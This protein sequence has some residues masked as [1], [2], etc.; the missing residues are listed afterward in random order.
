LQPLDS[1]SVKEWRHRRML[2]QQEV[3]DRAGTSL[4]TIQRIERGE[5]NVRPKTGR[6]VAEV[7]GVPIEELLP[8]VQAPL[9]SDEPHE[10]R[11]YFNFREAREQLEEYCE[12]WE[13][14]IS[15]NGLDDRAI[16]EFMSAGQGFIPV[17]DIALRAELH[18]LRRLTGLEGS[19]LIK[20]SEIAKA[21][22]RYL[23]VFSEIAKALRR[24]VEAAGVPASNVVDLEEA[25]E[26][27]ADM[28]RRAVG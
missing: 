26:R 22:D 3:A 28:P 23:D 4:F 6:A 10:E 2:S 7:L 21:N 14:R 9:W 15:K 24:L 5:G 12:Q 19:E 16:E 8:K 27:L 25:R 1:N 17:L 18:E 13:Q 11:H 20:R